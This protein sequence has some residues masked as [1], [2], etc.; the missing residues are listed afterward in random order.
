MV[1]GGNSGPYCLPVSG[2]TVTGDADPY[3]DPSVFAQMIKKRFGSKAFPRPINGP[4]LDD[5][6]VSFN[7]VSEHIPVFNVGA[8]C[9]GMANYHDIILR[10]VELSPC[11]VRDGDVLEHG[12]AFQLEGG[13]RVY[14]LVNQ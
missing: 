6:V 4:H 2:L 12:T 3:G 14:R 9:E 10:V 11:L 1:V 5:S 7:L 8:S 13:Y